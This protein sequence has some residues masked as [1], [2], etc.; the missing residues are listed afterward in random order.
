M[1]SEIDKITNTVSPT[2]LEPKKDK[3]LDVDYFVQCIESALSSE[4]KKYFDTGYNYY[5]LTGNN[6]VSFLKNF[7]N[8]FN[9]YIKMTFRDSDIKVEDQELII[10]NLNLLLKSIEL[11][12]SVFENF[13]NNYK[14]PKNTFD[15]NKLF[16]IITGYAIN[17]LKKDFRNQ[18]QR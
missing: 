16:M 5:K 14:L 15:S 8:L 6:S 3:S 4:L 9:D 17:N 2:S 1:S 13:V 10:E 7:F 18:S 12:F 11:N